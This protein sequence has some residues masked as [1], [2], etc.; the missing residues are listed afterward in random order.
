[1]KGSEIWVKVLREVIKH[2]VGFPPNRA[3][4]YSHVQY[5]NEEAN[6][7][8][9]RL[10]D[11]SLKKHQGFAACKFGTIELANIVS[12]LQEGQW[13]YKN[14]LDFIKGYP[15]PIYRYREIERLGN[16]AG[17]FPADV[18]YVN[19]FVELM[20]KDIPKVD[21]LAS[22]A[23]CERYIENLIAPCV[24][25]NLDSYYAPFL[26]DNPWTRILRNQRVLVIHPFAQSIKMQYKKRQS[27]FENQDV[28][29]EF[30]SLRVIQAVQSIAGNDCGFENWFVALEH[31]KKQMEQEDFDIALIGCGAYGFPLTIYA[32]QL[33]KVGIHL[34]GWLQ[35]LFGIYG[36]R[37]LEDQPQ[38]AK[39][40]NGNWIRPS[41]NELPQR[42]KEIEG[43][44]YW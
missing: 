22:Y 21:L 42:A 34:A 18:F 15:V 6:E 7:V 36:K 1:M 44:C 11:D 32:K 13:K 10:I 41:S 17:F 31:M 37:W 14:Y 26:F 40:I 20:L 28:L 9:H 27:L 25:V 33:G 2:T 5:F 39:Y 35:M 12:R 4:D 16:N 8:M 24:K 19:Q 3:V 43:G 23:F 29:P 30:K 38:Y